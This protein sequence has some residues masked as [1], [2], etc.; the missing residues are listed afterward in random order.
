MTPARLF[1][2]RTLAF[3]VALGFEAGVHSVSLAFNER[4]GHHGEVRTDLPVEFL[5]KM[6]FPA[7]STRVRNGEISLM[8]YSA[9]DYVRSRGLGLYGISN[10]EK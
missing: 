8:P 3:V 10:H 2:A 1:L 4:E 5:P 9:Y 7:S 6:P